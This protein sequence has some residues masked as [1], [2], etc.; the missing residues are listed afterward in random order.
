M[1]DEVKLAFVNRPHMVEN[2]EGFI[3]LEVL[4]PKENE[5]EIW[6]LTYWK[7]QESFKFWHKN[8]LKGAHHGIPPGLKLVPHSFKLRFFNHI[9]S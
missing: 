5:T 2:Q 1:E 4:S 7:D 6:L 3:K 8:H 9:A